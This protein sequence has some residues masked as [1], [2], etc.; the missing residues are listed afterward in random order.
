[1]RESTKQTNRIEIYVQTLG[2]RIRTDLLQPASLLRRVCRS[3]VLISASS[4]SLC[5]KARSGSKQLWAIPIGLKETMHATD[6][7]RSSFAT[8]I[9]VNVIDL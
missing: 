1:M 3:G 6:Q 4:H 5:T 8:K 2:R 9:H 7:V